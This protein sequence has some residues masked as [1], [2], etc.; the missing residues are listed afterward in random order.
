[1]GVIK[2]KSVINKIRKAKTRR[3]KR[4]LEKREPQVIEATK[5]AIFTRGSTASQR[6]VQLLKDF[7]L[8]KKP[9]SVY[10]NRKESWHPM[11]DSQ[12]LE[13]MS[14]KNN[15]TLFAFANHTKKRPNNVIIGR[16]FDDH[17]LDMYELG[18]DNYRSLQEFKGV[19]KTSVGTKPIVTFSGQAFDVEPDYQRLKNLL[20]DFFAGPD[21]EA[22]RLSGLEHC[23]QFVALDGKVLMRSYRVALKKSGTRLPR[24]EL[25]E[26]GPRVDLTVRR[27]RTAGQDLWKRALRR[28]E[29]EFRKG[30]TVKN[31]NKDG[32]GSTLGRIHMRRQNYRNLSLRKTRAFR[33]S[34]SE[35]PDTKKRSLVPVVDSVGAANDRTSSAETNGA[36]GRPKKRVRFES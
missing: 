2:D 15:S 11:D 29:V 6:C 36:E 7:C 25:L 28:P 31:I 18:F 10:F 22:I 16:T 34:S 35:R 9:N 13:R 20:L 24:V 30:K 23:I 4:F 17:V 33:K 8:L 14:A 19:P 26:M 12:P 5:T 3:G 21:V 1:M 27:V 32:L